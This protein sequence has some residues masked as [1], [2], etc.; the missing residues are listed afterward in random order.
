M[1]WKVVRFLRRATSG[2]ARPPMVTLSNSSG[3]LVEA[4]LKSPAFHEKKSPVCLE[5]E[6]FASHLARDLRLPCAKIVPV[7][8]T[9]E[10]IRMAAEVFQ[11]DGSMLQGAIPISKSLQNGPDLLI[12]S[13]S[14][15]TGWSEWTPV[16]PASI[17]Q[18]KMAAEIYFFDTLVQ[19]WDRVIH[20]P[21]L[22]IKNDLYGMIDQ[23]ESFVEAV[24]LEVERSYQSKPWMENGVANHSG[25]FEEHPLWKKIKNRRGI[26]FDAI[27]RKFK[28]LPQEQIESYGSGG[29][30]DIW[31]QSASERIS[32]Y[33][34]EAIENIETVRDA[35]E[36][37]RGS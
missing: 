26:S 24:G 36:V 30:F 19:N 5:R 21:N 20:N 37:N 17:N 6:W 7:E 33:I 31:S 29:E 3:T 27:V 15:G 34:F 10:L 14:L 8:V 9:S 12:G 32:E 13:I 25:E 1:N 22:L 28:R 18:L 35:I 16:A 11:D 2:R 4:Y 23:E